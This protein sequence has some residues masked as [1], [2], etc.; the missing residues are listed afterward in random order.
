MQQWVE[1][2]KDFSTHT[3][4]CVG[5]DLLRNL[6]AQGFRRFAVAI[7]PGLQKVG[8]HLLSASFSNY[9]LLFGRRY[10]P[11]QAPF[12]AY[13]KKSGAPYGTPDF[14]V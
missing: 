10:Q 12:L 8:V 9:N 5:W 13:V 4:V 7:T 14:L 2:T 11:V 3:L 6:A 1:K